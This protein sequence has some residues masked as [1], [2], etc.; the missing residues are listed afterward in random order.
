MIMLDVLLSCRLP[1]TMTQAMWAA[2]LD[3]RHTI[4][5]MQK[6]LDN[7]LIEHRVSNKLQAKSETRRWRLNRG[8]SE[9]DARKP[10]NRGRNWYKTTI[11]GEEYI[12]R[13][14]N[15]WSMFDKDTN[16]I[17]NLSFDTIGCPRRGFGYLEA[18]LFRKRFPHLGGFDAEWALKP[19]NAPVFVNDQR[20]AGE[21]FFGTTLSYK[22]FKGLEKEKP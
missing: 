19:S 2:N 14:K 10:A 9:E 5:T 22:Q 1:A 13:S 20:I 6:L 15:L 8:M 12:S 3:W 16:Y 18:P 21:V 17:G 4:K 11:K 7:E